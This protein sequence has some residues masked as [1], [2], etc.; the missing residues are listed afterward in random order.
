MCD[1]GGAGGG[2]YDPHEEPKPK[3]AK[4]VVK[5]IDKLIEKINKSD[6]EVCR[7]VDNNKLIYALT[8]TRTD[9]YTLIGK[10]S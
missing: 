7:A 10:E 4:K 8:K 1:W 9:L 2:Y 3:D 6:R 5:L